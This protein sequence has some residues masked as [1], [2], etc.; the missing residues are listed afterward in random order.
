MSLL[1]PILMCMHECEFECA[2]RCVF[3]C[4]CVCVPECHENM[5]SEKGLLLR[6]RGRMGVEQEWV[7]GINM[8]QGGDVPV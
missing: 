2:R 7:M 5:N 8:S 4:V 3:V 6:E 1:L